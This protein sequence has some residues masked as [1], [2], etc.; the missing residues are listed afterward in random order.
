[1]TLASLLTPD[2]VI[3]AMRATEHWPAIVELIDGLI[4]AGAFPSGGREEILEAF[5]RREDLRSTGVGV[6]IAI[7]HAFSD[8]I[9]EVTAVFGR[10]REGIEF[11]AADGVPVRYVVLFIVPRAEYSQ[12]LAVLGAI[13]K[14]LN[15]PEI[16]QQLAGAAD[17]E[18]ISD[19]LELKTA[20]V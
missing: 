18:E 6:G 3:P 8:R 5:R 19:I 15:N 13:A 11:D 10:S 20:R 2:R 17:A 1:M 9:T 12:H 7:P 4:E 14:T 16:R